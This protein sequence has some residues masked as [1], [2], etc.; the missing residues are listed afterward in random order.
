L[1][2]SWFA[3]KRRTTL[4]PWLHRKDMGCA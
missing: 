2:F 3:S 1:T 4:V